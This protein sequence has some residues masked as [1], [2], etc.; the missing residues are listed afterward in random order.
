VI[1]IIGA[2]GEI[3][4]QK[5][6]GI[7]GKLSSE[8]KVQI[9]LLDAELVFGREHVLSAFEH[10][11]RAFGNGTNTAKTLATELIL[12][13]SGDRQISVAI[14][15]M[16]IKDG[17]KRVAIAILDE[18]EDARMSELLE[19]LGLKR[20]DDVLLPE[21]KSLEAFGI[22]ENELAA[23]PEERRRDLV[24][25]KVALVDLIK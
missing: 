20:D 11:E 13:A 10:A 17:S 16:G 8:W 6:L 2:A 18:I 1:R 22:S 14:E 25:E 9:A 23:V 21:G 12:Y 3:D 4:V 19:K 7:V 24:L 5:V 15:K